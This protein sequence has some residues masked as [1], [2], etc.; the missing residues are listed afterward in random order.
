LINLVDYKLFD[1]KFR[2]VEYPAVQG[3]YLIRLA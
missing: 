2:R 3:Q 1:Y